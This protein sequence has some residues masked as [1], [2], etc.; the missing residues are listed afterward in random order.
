MAGS[1]T[2]LQLRTQVRKRANIEGET[3]R[4]TDAEVNG[5]I[6]K[7]WNEL[8][9]LIAS[10]GEDYYLAETTVTTS[11]GVSTYALAVAFLSLRYATATY[12]TWVHELERINVSEIDTWT[13]YSQSYSGAPAGYI[14]LGDNIQLV[15][16]PTAAYTI[17][18]KY[19]PRP[20]DMSLDADSIDM[21]A[22]WEEFIIWH[23]VMTIKAIDG[24]D[25]SQAAAALGRQHARVLENAQRRNQHQPK[26][27]IR[28]A[29]K[30][31]MVW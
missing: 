25:T 7:A 28:R 18:L 17:T 12:N 30:R 1:V 22:G 2:L 11:A 21:K 14:L 20:T 19:V 26:A 24:L 9:E 16:T 23:A 6:N 27:I 8:Y 3:D 29:Y 13:N 31:R 10:T 15:P 4:H 5:Y